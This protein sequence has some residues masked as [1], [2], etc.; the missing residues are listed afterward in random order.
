[1][2]SFT[3]F[4]DGAVEF[5][6]GLLVDNSK[7]YW[8]DQREVYEAHVRAPMLALLADLEAEFG[9]GKVFRPFRDLRF[10]N[11]KT[12][13][14]THCGATAGPY[15]VQVGAD[16]LMAAAGHYQMAADQVGRFR[17]AVDDERRGSDLA[18]RLAAIEADGITIAGEMLK[19]RP[20]G[21]DAEHPR[22]EL[23]R[24]KSLYGWRR[25]PPDDVLHEAGAVQRVA[26]A[27]RSLRPL[28]E[29]LA[30]HVGPSEL[31]RR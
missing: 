5:Y 13:Y 10:S 16:G 20:R 1:M 8:T 15:Y 31:P 4:G 27:W 22:L 29:W 12:P 21:I 24:H 17:T 11:D 26:S 23:L 19:T 2:S 30:D 14:K 18:K 9:P 3:G 28:T 7:A 6:D 25:W